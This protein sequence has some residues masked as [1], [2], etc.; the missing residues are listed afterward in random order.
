MYRI[1]GTEDSSDTTCNVLTLNLNAYDELT[2]NSGITLVIQG[3]LTNS[4]GTI[5]NFGT[6]ANYHTVSNQG[7]IANSGII[8][9]SGTITNSDTIWN[10]CSGLITGN[11]VIGNNPIST[12]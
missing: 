8:V 6:L 1:G 12:C 5:I 4:G 11:S 10:F 9:N 7:M 3:V 2:I